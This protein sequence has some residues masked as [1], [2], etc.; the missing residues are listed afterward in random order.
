[1]RSE[2]ASMEKQVKESTAA[3]DKLTAAQQ[4]RTAL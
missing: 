4:K 2:E 1:M 3:V